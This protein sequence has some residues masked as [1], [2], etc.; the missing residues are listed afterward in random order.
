MLRVSRIAI[1][2]VETIRS[3]KSFVTMYKI[4]LS[5]NLEENHNRYLY[6]RKKLKSQN[7]VALTNF[8]V[9]N[10]LETNAEKRGRRH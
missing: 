3:L 2:K 6:R 1:N 10:S 4:T 9:T 5:Q 7:L 8:D